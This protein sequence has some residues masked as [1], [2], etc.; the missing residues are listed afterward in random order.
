MLDLSITTVTSNTNIL[1]EEGL[2]KRIGI[3]KSTGGRKP[4]IV[5]FIKNAYASLGVNIL[6]YKVDIILTDLLS[7]II[8]KVSF[9]ILIDDMD[10]ILNSIKKNIIVL[11]LK[12][13]IL[14]S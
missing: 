4:V 1:L 10:Q 3:A 14:I 11:L 6:P 9:E 13:D 5:Q 7:N 8:D 2:I 12:N